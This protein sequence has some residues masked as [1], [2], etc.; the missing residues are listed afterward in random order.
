MKYMLVKPIR[1]SVT[2][3]IAGEFTTTSGQKNSFHVHMNLMMAR[4]AR[5]GATAGTTTRQKTAHSLQPSM[6]AAAR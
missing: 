6:R 1:P 2:V 3:F 4:V 5:A